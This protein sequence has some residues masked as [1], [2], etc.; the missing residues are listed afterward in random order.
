MINYNGKGTWKRGLG[1]GQGGCPGG[2]AVM[3]SWEFVSWR[4]A[5]Q[6]VLGRGN[7]LVK[8]RE[9]SVG[10][11]GPQDPVNDGEETG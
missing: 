2:R 8:A 9:W 3:A 5:E 7:S 1:G 6:G 4:S 11:A 10:L